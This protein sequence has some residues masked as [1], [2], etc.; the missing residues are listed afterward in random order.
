MPRG[1]L[2]FKDERPSGPELKYV[3]LTACSQ[4]WLAVFIKL[5]K[6][7]WITDQ[8]PLPSEFGK[9][10]ETIWN[11]WHRVVKQRH[12]SVLP[13][14]RRRFQ[15]FTKPSPILPIIRLWAV[16]GIASGKRH[17]VYSTAFKIPF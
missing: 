4:R 10:C 15:L 14:C 3:L 5:L 11:E 9:P 13:D 6:D 17:L 8:Q 7:V 12:L 16:F 2:S 1:R